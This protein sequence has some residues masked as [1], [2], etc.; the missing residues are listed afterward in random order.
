L[1]LAAVEC[2][3]AKV[4]HGDAE[5]PVVAKLARKPRRLGVELRR[6]IPGAALVGDERGDVDADGPRPGGICVRAKGE[7]LVRRR[8]A[9]FE[10]PLP[11][12]E[13]ACAPERVEA[14]VS[15]AL[16]AGCKRRLEPAAAL[17]PVASSQPEEPNRAG[18]PQRD[19]GASA[20]ER[21]AEHGA[22]VVVLGLEPVEPDRR[23]PALQLG[24]RD[25]SEPEEVGGV[26]MPE[27]LGVAAF[28][29]SLE[30][31]L[32]DRLQHPEPLSRVAEK[33]FVDQSLKYVHVGCADG[34]GRF[35]GAAAG[36]DS[37][38]GEQPLLL[39]AEEVVAPL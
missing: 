14:K 12:G 24:L 28:L 8:L 18:E 4:V 6:L 27:V 19:V 22:D 16:H 1:V 29:Q 31:E 23:A 7:K 25:L 26:P 30:R 36:E 5:Q 9:T 10:V 34:F 2:D 20:L 11:D 38:P 15:V 32:A 35:Y 17:A 37:Q 13:Q 33:A 39:D 21:V 3:I